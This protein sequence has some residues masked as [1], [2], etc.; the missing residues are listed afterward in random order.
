MEVIIIKFVL[1]MTFLVTLCFARNPKSSKTNI[2]SH[3][4]VNLNE[5]KV[6][7]TN[8]T[9]GF[10]LISYLPHVHQQKN[11][12]GIE[13][14]ITINNKLELIKTIHLFLHERSCIN[15]N[16]LQSNKIILHQLNEEHIMT[17]ADV[18]KLV[19]SAF[20]DK[21]TIFA[22]A[23]MYFNTNVNM[24]LSNGIDNGDV[25]VLKSIHSNGNYKR[26]YYGTHYAFLSIGP[27]DK[28]RSD[29]P[30]ENLQFEI[31][32]PRLDNENVIMKIFEQ[33]MRMTL[34]SSTVAAMCLH[35]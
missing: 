34:K 24:Y 31:D 28:S 5:H 14:A 30:R 3:P 25:H 15:Q 23:N 12:H 35:E 32:S 16:D 2:K 22:R 10:H 8:K 29:V 17:F 13:K 33:S 11:C 1:L 21:Y 7:G 19:N 18:L 9:E 6:Y 26:G 27:W 20:K 4:S